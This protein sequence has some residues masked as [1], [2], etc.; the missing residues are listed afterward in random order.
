MMLPEDTEGVRDQTSHCILRLLNTK[1]EIS[2]AYQGS[3][4]AV[5]LCYICICMLLYWIFT[6][7]VHV[8]STG[9][10]HPSEDVGMASLVCVI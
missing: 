3:R 2:N 7:L 9:D 10:L 1:E 4:E 6:Y 8:Y 5:L